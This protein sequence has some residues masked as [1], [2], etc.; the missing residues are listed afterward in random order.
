MRLQDPSLHSVQHP[1]LHDRSQRRRRT[2][3]LVVRLHTWRD[4]WIV[5]RL[6]CGVER[7][8]RLHHPLW[9]VLVEHRSA[10]SQGTAFEVVDNVRLQVLNVP[11][12]RH[13]SAVG[14]LHFHLHHFMTLL[15]EGSNDFRRA[16]AH[17]VLSQVPLRL[18][19]QQRLYSSQKSQRGSFARA[20]AIHPLPSTP[21]IAHKTQVRWQMLLC[22]QSCQHMIVH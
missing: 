10:L 13:N 16:D 22:L 18:F 20:I 21:Q 8:G 4:R 2:S 14:L 15:S 3:V 6:Q 1:S 7:L 5:L 19:G 17:C 12:L 11:V 9:V